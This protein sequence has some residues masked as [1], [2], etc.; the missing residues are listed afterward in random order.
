MSAEI[1]KEIQLDLRFK[2]SLARRR[3]N[4]NFSDKVGHRNSLN[5]PK[6]DS[7]GLTVSGYRIFQ[8]RQICSRPW[9]WTTAII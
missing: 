1:N 5:P 9:L 3:H 7:D 6:T 8:F 2:D 4:K